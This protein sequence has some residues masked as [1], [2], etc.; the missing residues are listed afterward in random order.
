LDDA[1]QE[2]QRKAKSYSTVRYLLQSRFGYTAVSQVPESEIAE[3][4]GVLRRGVPKAARRGG[5]ITAEAYA[6]NDMASEVYQ[7][8]NARGATS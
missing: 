6:L 5:R 8:F 3:V 1:F 7:K 4:I 2:A